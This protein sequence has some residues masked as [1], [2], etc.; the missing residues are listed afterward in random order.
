MSNIKLSESSINSIKEDLKTQGMNNDNIIVLNVGNE[1]P[2]KKTI[3]D[4]NTNIN[5]NESI[6]NILSVESKNNTGLIPF[7]HEYKNA[8]NSGIADE[9]IYE[10]FIS[11][12]SA[13]NYLNAVDTE[14]SA[15]KDRVGKYKEKIDFKKILKTMEQTSSSYLVPLIED[16]VIDYV[17][18]KNPNTRTLLKNTL[19]NFSYDPFVRNMIQIIDLDVS[20]ENTMFMGESIEDI[21]SKVNVEKIYSPI[22]FIK[23]NECIFNVKGNYY[24]RKGNNIIKLSKNDA[25]SLNESFKEFCN[26]I[27]DN[28]VVINSDNNT[29]NLYWDKDK[30]VINESNVVI[31]NKSFTI[32][33][34]DNLAYTS[35]ISGTDKSEM[36]RYVKCLMENFDNIA[37]IDFVR[38][39]VLKNSL[40]ESADLFRIKNNIFIATHDNKHGHH[41][42]YRNVNPI[43][44]AS[45]I[46]EHLDLNVSKIFEDLMPK[47]EKIKK[48]IDESKVEYESLINS[49]EEKL[50]KIDSI[51]N[52]DSDD[53]SVEEVKNVIKEELEKTKKEYKE[54]CSKADKF[55]EAEGEDESPEDMADEFDDHFVDDDSDILD[56]NIDRGG[57]SMED[58]TEPI[59]G[60]GDEDIYTD[61]TEYDPTM[62]YSD[63]GNF[64]DAESM[65]NTGTYQIVKVLFDENVK[66]ST[67][68]PRGSVYVMIPMINPNG[69]KVTEMQKITFTLDNSGWVV[70]NNEYMPEAM[71]N[72]IVSAIESVPEFDEIVSSMDN[73]E[74]TEHA[75]SAEQEIQLPMEQSKIIIDEPVVGP[76]IEFDE[77]GMVGESVNTKGK[78]LSIPLRTLYKIRPLTLL[79]DLRNKNVFAK[80][81]PEKDSIDITLSSNDDTV[82]VKSYL[83]DNELYT[84]EQIV[85]MF[86]VLNETFHV[87]EGIE[88]KITDDKTGKKYTVDLSNISS[89]KDEE[90]SDKEKDS[91]V[92]VTFNP[93]DSLLY[94]PDEDE[95]ED[96]KS[97][98][99][100]ESNKEESSDKNESAKEEIKK[101]KFKFKFK[102]KQLGEVHAIHESLEP[103]V[104]DKVSYKGKKGQIISI[105]NN[106]D[107][108]LEVAGST[109]EA[110]PSE[111]KILTNRVDTVPAPFK[112]DKSTLKALYEQ[113]VECGI[114]MN[115]ICISQPNCYVKYSDWQEAKED[116]N[117]NILM[118][119]E[120]HVMQ[121]KYVKIHEDIN[122]FANPDD[123]VAG[124][125]VTSDGEAVRNV[126]IN[127]ADY[128]TAEGGNNGIRVLVDTPN[129]TENKKLIVLPKDSLKTLTI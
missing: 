106:G 24:A 84:M 51:T 70:V 123:Y 74:S 107:I 7:L 50:A 73:Y 120:S 45:I 99:N 15:L 92:E 9:M 89:G 78:I 90:K 26:I 25:A 118:L 101:P 69:D 93:E 48:E 14:L 47:P 68:Y 35:Y 42:F 126:L 33:D 17:E 122:S 108:I 52:E 3:N 6:N 43:Q 8:I 98:E 2:M 38:H 95:D 80:Y 22:Q 10:D 66:T 113:M 30:I 67:K 121:K 23:E 61:V 94:N 16:Y 102:P 11:G 21:N 5:L 40:N 57:D 91:E 27:N 116:D 12:A 31:D 62:V 56:V 82:K 13:W 41:T 28:R 77:E 60:E 65:E 55:L 4:I 112:F 109:V 36:Y 128:M 104:L 32:S 115:N 83:L 54:Y 18:N 110:A 114:Y 81:N 49:L 39:I 97:E 53:D 79:R 103:Q 19:M 20:K 111:I 124:V 72:A 87:N 75:M 125:E 85:E 63:S 96:K 119:N 34:I 71:Y 100:T 59:T 117:I 46:N 129:E 44:T 1:V 58:V 88:L 127:I 86:P 105:T 37:H 64:V 29:I 76:D